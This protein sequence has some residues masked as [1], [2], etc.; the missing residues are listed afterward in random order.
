MI[1]KKFWVNNVVYKKDLVIIFSR[2]KIYL[3]CTSRGGC[4]NNEWSNINL[5]ELARSLL[6]KAW[7]DVSNRKKDHLTM[8][9]IIRVPWLWMNFLKLQRLW[10]NRTL[11]QGACT[12]YRNRILHKVY[13]L[14]QHRTGKIFRHSNSWCRVIM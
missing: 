1:L 2:N 4:L 6:F 3:S 7:N 10:K 13:I 11:L 9:I 8:A 14:Y 5:T 12:V